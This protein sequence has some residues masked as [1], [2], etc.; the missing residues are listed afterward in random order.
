MNVLDLPVEGVQFLEEFAQLWDGVLFI[1]IDEVREQFLAKYPDGEFDKSIQT[2]AAARSSG[3]EDKPMS[4]GEPRIEPAMVNMEGN[5]LDAFLRVLVR[6]VGLLPLSAR[7]PEAPAHHGNFRRETVIHPPHRNRSLAVFKHQ[8]LGLV[9]TKRPIDVHVLCDM[10][11]FAHGQRL[12]AEEY[13][14]SFR[15][16]AQAIESLNVR[17]VR[18]VDKTKVVI[19]PSLKNV[20]SADEEAQE[21]ELEEAYKKW[22]GRNYKTVMCRSFEETQKCVY[23]EDCEAAHGQTDMLTEAQGKHEAVWF[24]ALSKR[25]GVGGAEYLRD[26]IIR[27]FREMT[28]VSIDQIPLLYLEVN[29][30]LLDWRSHSSGTHQR[31]WPWLKAELSD[32][33]R[34]H[35]V[36]GSKTPWACIKESIYPYANPSILARA[37]RRDPSILAKRLSHLVRR[38]LALKTSMMKFMYEIHYGSVGNLPDLDPPV[39]AFNALLK[40]ITDPEIRCIGE[41]V[42][43]IV[44]ENLIQMVRERTRTKRAAGLLGQ[45]PALSAHPPQHQ[46]HQDTRG[47]H[48]V[49]MSH[50]SP[51]QYYDRHVFELPYRNNPYGRPPHIPPASGHN[52]YDNRFNASTQQQFDRPR[53]AGAYVDDPRRYE[54]ARRYFHDSDSRSRPHPT[55]QNDVGYRGEDQFVSSYRTMGERVSVDDSLVRKVIRLFDG[56]VFLRLASLIAVYKSYYG[57]PDMPWYRNMPP[58]SRLSDWIWR[59]SDTF[60]LCSFKSPRDDR[61]WVRL[62]PHVATPAWQTIRELSDERLDGDPDV[63]SRRL[64]VL[65]GYPGEDLFSLTIVVLLKMYQEVYGR[66]LSCPPIFQNRVEDFISSLYDFTIVNA[67]WVTITYGH[68]NIPVNHH[69]LASRKRSHSATSP[70]VAPAPIKIPKHQ[71]S[72]ISPGLTSHSSGLYNKSP[73]DGLTALVDLTRYL[74][75]VKDEVTIEKVN[76]GDIVSW[77]VTRKMKQ[78]ASLPATPISPVGPPQQVFSNVLYPFPVVRNVVERSEEVNQLKS[79]GAEDNVIFDNNHPDTDVEASQFLRMMMDS[80]IDQAGNHT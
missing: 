4:D 10:F 6:L 53:S 24:K 57:E 32:V 11:Y 25:R 23:G 67:E 18:I 33:L 7:D 80:V 68:R 42:T 41:D 50:E 46:H 77:R 12:V 19:D 40:Q 21:K 75:S 49:A 69:L 39:P 3:A 61:I 72:I 34:F 58:S 47:A 78:S 16:V 63:E 13:N 74:E 55:L 64:K 5:K 62:R 48:D 79:Y 36:P 65:V 51:R 9:R 29:H 44:D 60:V 30:I 22:K 1:P 20:L 54:E 45:A 76:P 37:D 59:E 43:V 56:C 2:Y 27:I 71:D 38:N 70:I 73:P 17:C 8:L 35:D 28:Y 52:Y 31:Y 15:S 66:E 26:D 14:S